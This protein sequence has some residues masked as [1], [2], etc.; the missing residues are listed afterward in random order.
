MNKIQSML[1]DE[2]YPWLYT[3]DGSQVQV[4]EACHDIRMAIIYFGSEISTG[5]TDALTEAFFA[6]NCSSSTRV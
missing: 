6:A 1:H 5:T 2:E 3:S 4:S